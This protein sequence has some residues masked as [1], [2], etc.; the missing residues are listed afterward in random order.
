MSYKIIIFSA[1]FSFW[2]SAPGNDGKGIKDFIPS[3][4]ELTGFVI[5]EQPAFYDIN[6][7]WNYINGAAP[8]YVS[9]GFQELVTFIVEKSQDSLEV[10]IDIYDMGD[11]L[12]A[13]GIFSSEKSSGDFQ[14][15]FG[16]GSFRSDMTLYF[17]Q[18]RYY[19]KMM[20]YDI[21]PETRNT[22]SHLSKMISKKIPVRGS[23]PAIFSIFPQNGQIKGS[24]KY[25]PKDVLGQE[26]FTN[27]YYC[28]YQQEG[29]IYRIYLIENESVSTAKNSFQNYFDFFKNQQQL[30]ENN[31]TTDKNTFC[32]KD[33]YYGDVFIHRGGRYIIGVMG[34]KDKMAANAIVK[35]MFD[36]LSLIETRP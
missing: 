24:H 34:G 18:N 19:I 2:A 7:L 14:I 30:A 3:A 1:F 6:N 12:T 13:F 16:S 33:S 10:V 5:T 32:G 9:Y 11:T 25:I 28:E 27:G 23:I 29:S 4:Q 22:L 31:L 15:E 35:K 8:G 26:Y 17:W 21:I 20:A 36:G